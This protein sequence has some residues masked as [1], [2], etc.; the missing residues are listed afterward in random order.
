[1]CGQMPKGSDPKLIHHFP[2]LNKALRDFN[3][4]WPGDLC[5]SL[6]IYLV[7]NHQRY[8]IFIVDKRFIRQNN[9]KKSHYDKIADALYID[10]VR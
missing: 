4:Q 8:K 10:R 1:M 7:S 3:W 2:E 6:I 5:L 9:K